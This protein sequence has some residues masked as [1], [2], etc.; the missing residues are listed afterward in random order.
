MLKKLFEVSGKDYDSSSEEFE[1]INWRKPACGSSGTNWIER[2]DHPAVDF[3][4]GSRHR[5]G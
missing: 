2:S 1:L 4:G 5:L 3:C